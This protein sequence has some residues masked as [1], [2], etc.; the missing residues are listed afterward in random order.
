MYP[1]E[2]IILS[3]DGGLE[4]SIVFIGSYS[5]LFSVMTSCGSGSVISFCSSLIF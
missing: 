1:E 4:R 2:R 3:Q 5:S